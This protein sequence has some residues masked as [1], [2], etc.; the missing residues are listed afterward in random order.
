MRLP[1]A[2]SIRFH[3]VGDTG[4]SEDFPEGDVARAMTKDF[5][6]SKPA[7]SPAFFFHLGDVIYGAH[8]DQRYRQEFYEPY[9]HYPGKII[10][11]PGN[12]DGETFPET[13]PKTLRAFLQISVRRAKSCRK[14]PEQFPSN[15]ESAGRVLVLGRSL[16]T[17]YR[18]V[19]QRSGEP[20]LHF[21]T[22]PDK[23][24]RTG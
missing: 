6:I 14:L 23:L 10:A 19:F 17:D 20:G 2:P 13:D 24:R 9:V 7:Q 1:A 12:H 15:D 22:F 8:K 4:R 5:D 21:G 18:F 16:R 3:S 11:I